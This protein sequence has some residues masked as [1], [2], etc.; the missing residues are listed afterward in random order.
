[1][2]E[3]KYYIGSAGPYFYDDAVSL[4][5][6]DNPSWNQGA[7]VTDGGLETD[8]ARVGEQVVITVAL[9]NEAF[10]RHFLQ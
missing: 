2:T 9:S 7:L 10:K 3:R 6:P 4:N 1:M 8:S 5:D